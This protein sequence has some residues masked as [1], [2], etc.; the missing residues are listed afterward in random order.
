VLAV[1]TVSRNPAFVFL[2]TEQVFSKQIV[3]FLIENFSGFAIL[4]SNIH[5]NWTRFFGSS[6]KDDLRYT[7]SDCFETFPF[8]ENWETNPTLETI[9]KEYYEFRA[10]LM[11]RNNQGLTDTYNRFHDPNERDSDILKLRELHAKM[12]RA[13]LDAYGWTDIPTTCEFL[14]DY[15][16]EEDE[17]NSRRKKPWRYRWPEEVHDEVLARLLDLN[18][19]RHE[20]EILGGKHAETKA[21]SKKS[22]KPKAA[23]STQTNVKQLNLLGE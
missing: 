3:L 19:K 7:P 16:E 21:K 9:G 13:V 8:S 10:D 2:N 14:L 17:S 4:Q 11:I 12:D 23:K 22:R 20:A 18:Q 15:E 6:L 5:L 1:A